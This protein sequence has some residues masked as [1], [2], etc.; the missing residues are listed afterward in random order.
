MIEF[1]A[2]R[3][4]HMYIDTAKNEVLALL[5]EAERDPERVLAVAS[6]RRFNAAQVTQ[7]QLIGALLQKYGAAPQ[8]E[9]DASRYGP[10]PG[11]ILS[12][13]ARAGCQPQMRDELR[14]NWSGLENAPNLREAQNLARQFRGPSL[15][16]N[17]AHSIIY[18]ECIPSVWASVGE[19][20]EGNLHLVIWSIDM[21]LVDE[22]AQRPDPQTKAD[23]DDGSQSLIENAA[24]I[25]L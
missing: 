18:S 17:E 15:M 16:Y 19:D 21:A 13:G 7:Q 14:P 22:V 23:G 5:R 4:G 11:Q 25:D 2:L 8:T 3:N 6:Y 10:R 20:G 24:D 12:W 1:Q 9:S